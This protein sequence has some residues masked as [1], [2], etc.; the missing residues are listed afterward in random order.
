MSF[1]C[2]DDVL[3]LNLATSSGLFILIL[4]T[5]VLIYPSFLRVPEASFASYHRFHSAR[6]FWIVAPLTLLDVL[7]SLALLLM[8]VK[9]AWGNAVLCLLPL[10]GTFAFYAPL[11]SKIE[12]DFSWG[13]VNMLVKNNF[14]RVLFWGLKFFHAFWMMGLR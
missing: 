14:W 1:F 5:Q 10:L 6:I 9:G 12:R 4:L 8:A 7:A 3:C 13:L 11:H 2:S